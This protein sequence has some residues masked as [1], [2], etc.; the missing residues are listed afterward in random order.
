MNK[1]EKPLPVTFSV[2]LCVNKQQPW[3]N[4]AIE[5]ILSQNDGDFEFLIAANACTDELWER[6]Q[7]FTAPDARVRLFR[8]DIGQLAFNLNLLADKAQGEY[9][10]RM[11]A[12]DISEP[13]RILC[14]RQALSDSQL[15]IL[16]SAVFLI[17]ENGREVGHMNFPETT[18]EIRR[19]FPW[20]TVFCHPSVAIKRSFLLSLR[21][22]LGGFVSEDTDLWL[23]AIHAGARMGN[24]SKPLLRYRVHSQQSLAS[25]KGYA[26]VAGHWLRELLIAPSWYTF[27]GFCIALAKSLFTPILPGVRHYGRSKVKKPE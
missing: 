20:R 13:D 10:V 22:Y 17:D 11:D 25:R 2:V 7:T 9:L 1:C 21:G 19:V 15:D 4:E 14:L 18:A 6:L 3:L 26:E 24:L 8:S 12:D 16:G 5:S 27:S 23:R